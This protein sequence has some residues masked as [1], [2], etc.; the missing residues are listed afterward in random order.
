M[1]KNKD[2]VTVEVIGGNCEDV[3]G[4]CTQISFNK[5]TVLFECGMIQSGHTPLEN[6]QLNKRMLANIKH[7]NKIEYVFI[8]HCHADHIALI[9]ALYKNGFKGITIAPEKSTIIL[10]E[11]WLDSA[12]INQRD[13]ELISLKKE[14]SIEPL[15]DETDV[16]TALRYVKEYKSKELIK[17]DDEI[18]IRYIPAGHILLSMQMELYVSPRSNLTK[19]ILFTSDLGNDLTKDKQIFVEKFEPIYKSNLVIGECTYAAKNRGMNQKDVE[20]DVQKIKTVIE[21]YCIS[22][23]RRVLIPTF[24]LHRTPYLLW[25]LYNLFGNDESF[26]IPIIIDSPLSNR[27]LD[28]YSSIL[29]DETKNKFDEMMSW[30]NIKRIITP[31][32]SK[33]AIAD[34]G[35]KVIISSSGMLTAGRSVKWTASILPSYEDCILFIGYCTDG[36][37]GDKIKHGRTQKTININGRPIKN[38]C[39]II[40]LKSFSSHAQRAFLLKYYSDIH[41]EKICLVHSDANDRLEFAEDLR[42]EI[43]NKSRTT[44]V[45]PATKGMVINL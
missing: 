1:A 13:A 22:N 35:P 39:N 30:K 9:P 34:I 3:T 16:E 20:T 15:Y 33:A 24:S 11:M 12:H 10:R 37:L 2:K 21:Q 27:L 31:E 29:E 7:K 36:S 19:K 44:K 26:K 18:S 41:A 43:K 42:Q 5:R 4:S 28:C 32:D 40:D 14:K 6:Y 8:G 38:R 23:H 17:I 25:I 45:V